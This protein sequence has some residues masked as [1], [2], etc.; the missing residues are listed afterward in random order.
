MLDFLIKNATIID[1]T[2]SAGYPVDIGIQGDRIV[3]IGGLSQAEAGEIISA[4]GMVVAPGFIDMHSHAD[5]SLPISPTANSKIHQGVT[6]ELVG[7]CGISPAP[8]DDQ[9]RQSAMA[10]SILD[11]PGMDWA[12]DTFNSYLDRLR[13]TGISVNVGAL[14]GHGTIRSLVMGEG[15][16]LPNENQIDKM[17]NEVRLAMQAGA[18]GLSTGLIYPPNVY[19]S[20]DEIVALARCAADEG[21]IYASHIRGEADTVL[22]AVD[23]AIEIGKRANIPVEISH[24][25]AKFHPNWH[26][27]SIIL[28]KIEKARAV[29]LD[30]TADMYPYTALNT[31]LSALLPPWV[32][33]GGK[34][35]MLHRLQ[36]EIDRARIRQDLSAVAVQDQPG[37]WE[38]TFIS[39]CP[40]QADFEGRH[41]Q[42]LA[43][44]IGVSPETAVMD[45]LIEVESNVE[46]I[47]FLMSD[48]NLELGLRSPNV[49]IGSDGEGRS[50]E[51]PLAVGKP[52]PRNYG[53]FPRVL[54]HYVREKKLFSLEEAVYKMTGLPAEKLHL[55][56]RGLLKPGFFAD[57]VIFDPETV[58][59]RATFIQPHQY[60]AGIPTVFVNGKVVIREGKH[61]QARPGRCLKKPTG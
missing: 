33:V 48:E 37:Y 26:K 3:A 11:G 20:T 29:G 45:I 30:V 22:K 19:S 7:N 52:H 1:G 16:G 18:F 10:N 35:A 42:D 46:M 61:T 39:A 25:K 5:F 40:K 15:D 14:V 12:W 59:D 24:L 36:N 28:E 31:S 9:S 6:F 4:Q 8:I 13:T 54:G 51:G 2:G 23:E 41:L 27:M 17:K 56:Q 58:A 34:N 53:T 43:A 47:Q 60:P 21:G 57:V 50:A 32:H 55:H 49:M 38:R 44:E